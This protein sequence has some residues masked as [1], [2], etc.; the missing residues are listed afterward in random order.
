ML[1]IFFQSPNIHAIKVNSYDWREFYQTSQRI[2]FQSGEITRCPGLLF[3]W[4]QH[5]QELVSNLQLVLM[6]HLTDHRQ[7]LCV[8]LRKR[9]KKASEINLHSVQVPRFYVKFITCTV[10]SL[11]CKNFEHFCV[12]LERLYPYSNDPSLLG[13]RINLLSGKSPQILV[14]TSVCDFIPVSCICNFCI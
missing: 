12:S 7:L 3:G 2:P 4:L 14:I 5:I 6:V 11:K 13:H 8:E 9:R 1:K 10:S